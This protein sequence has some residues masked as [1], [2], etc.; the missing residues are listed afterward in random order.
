MEANRNPQLFLDVKYSTEKQDN[1]DVKT[2]NAYVVEDDVINDE[3]AL[4]L[5]LWTE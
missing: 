5:I 4:L 3:S 2:M 1:T